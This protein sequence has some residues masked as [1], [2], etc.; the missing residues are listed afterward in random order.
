MVTLILEYP[1]VP[2]GIETY[3][4]PLALLH[5]IEDEDDIKDILIEIA[6]RKGITD[7]EELHGEVDL[8]MSGDKYGDLDDYI[9]VEDIGGEE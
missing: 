1:A 6:A 7:I 5:W 4:K 2:E 8:I 9:T 3:G